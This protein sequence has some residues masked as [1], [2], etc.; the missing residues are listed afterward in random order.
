MPS[1]M[2]AKTISG[3]L[4]D[5]HTTLNAQTQ[6]YEVIVVI[7]GLVDDTLSV[8]KKRNDPQVKIVE[9]HK[10][11]GKGQ[12]LRS[13]IAAAKATKYIGYVDSDLDISPRALLDA[14]RLLDSNYEVDLVVGSKL[15]EDSTVSYPILRKFQSQI[16]ARMIDVFFQ[17]GLDDTQSGLKLGRAELVKKSAKN[18]STDGFAFDLEFLLRAKRLGGRFAS[19]P[20]QLNYQFSSTISARKYF[21]TILEVFRILALS[22]RK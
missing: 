5:L 1:Y 2:A 9:H 20:I 8:V 22:L 3:A 14:I 7:D 16:F 4:T 19:V 17:F 18:T 12:A 13:G 10:N 11:L 6:N 21:E 15:H